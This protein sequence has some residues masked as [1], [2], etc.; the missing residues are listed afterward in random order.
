MCYNMR[1]WHVRGYRTERV[2]Y[3]CAVRAEDLCRDPT[4]EAADVGFAIQRATGVS[5]RGV[6]LASLYFG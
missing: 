3:A 2:T 6:D 1:S 4:A 5:D